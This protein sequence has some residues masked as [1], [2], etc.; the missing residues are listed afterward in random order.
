LLLG[1][2]EAQFEIFSFRHNHI[3]VAPAAM[4]DG[5]Q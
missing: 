5:C 4:A 2:F 3:I 1:A